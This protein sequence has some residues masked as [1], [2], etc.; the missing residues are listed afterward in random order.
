MALL[1]AYADSDDVATAPIAVRGCLELSPKK[2]REK[3]I[4]VSQ[5]IVGY[6]DIKGVEGLA[7]EGNAQAQATETPVDGK[8][9]GPVLTEALLVAQEQLLE[10]DRRTQGVLPRDAR[11]RK[12]GLALLHDVRYVGIA[13]PAL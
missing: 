9:Q 4:A 1:Q 5:V 3:V 7:L 13:K 8:A 12:R 11:V 6:G 2:V 10:Q